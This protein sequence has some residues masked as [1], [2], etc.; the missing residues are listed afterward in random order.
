MFKLFKNS[1]VKNSKALQKLIL[2]SVVILI[3]PTALLGL[4]L[5]SEM[6]SILEKNI[7]ESVKSTNLN[8]ANQINSTLSDLLKVSTSISL[9][10]SFLPHNV[11]DDLVSKKMLTTQLN[12]IASANNEIIDIFYNLSGSDLLITRNQVVSL[13]WLDDAVIKLPQDDKTAL[14]EYLQS[15]N[16]VKIFPSRKVTVGSDTPREVI[17]CLLPV[18]HSNNSTY[19]TLGIF[20]KTDEMRSNITNNALKQYIENIY[21]TDSTGTVIM[22]LTDNNL[23]SLIEPQNKDEIY[24]VNDYIITSN[25]IP[26][27]DWNISSII[28][29][30]NIMQEVSTANI[31]ILLAVLLVLLLGIIIS[32]IL[33]FQNYRPIENL[34]NKT[35]KIFG[36]SADNNDE[37]IAIDNAFNI[38]DS[39]NIQ[40]QKAI[41]I[42]KPYAKRQILYDLINQNNT[43]TDGNM[44]NNYIFERQMYNVIIVQY[45][46]KSLKNELCE[47]IEY[48][49]LK[50]EIDIYYIDSH[51][52][53]LIFILAFDIDQKDIVL[54]LDLAK[55]IGYKINLYSGDFYRH[56]TDITK[57]YLEASEK[58]SKHE[59]QASS[60]NHSYPYDAILQIKQHLNKHEYT[61][62]CD[63]VSELVQ[64]FSDEMP[65]FFIR[66]ISLDILTLFI[67]YCFDSGLISSDIRLIYNNF[68]QNLQTSNNI[69]K[70][71][72]ETIAV[73]Q[74]LCGMI[75]NNI[76]IKNDIAENMLSYINLNCFKCD[77]SLKTMAHNFGMSPSYLSIAFKQAT[78][79]NLSQYIWELRLNK[80]KELL[81]STDD[82]INSIAMQVGYNVPNSFIRKFRDTEGIP[83]NEWKQRNKND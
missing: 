28:F 46:D 81:R 16:N 33:S 22:Q 21:I 51:S 27:F 29:R 41:N 82:S 38:L 25:K 62:A 9:N 2:S 75:E 36:N 77:F 69:E 78:N 71:Q 34:K 58:L 48:Y 68:A 35:K 8:V 53:T 32:F 11:S 24:E 14:L 43:F 50:H 55:D 20:L 40:L 5:K 66:C 72:Q 19:G 47:D 70:L 23:L 64:N 59:T 30:K 60:P 57:S 6:V 42:F 49:F 26:I 15:P 4:I 17:V 3:M 37:W 83:P 67:S 61:D 7:I 79:Q 74:K 12:Q 18:G 63:I 13:K 31:I 65:L 76:D 45:S 80:A 10:S 44:L 56:I 54:K 1:K 39:H 52:D 73:C